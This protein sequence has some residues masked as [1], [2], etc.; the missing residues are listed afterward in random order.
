MKLKKKI[1]FLLIVAVLVIAVVFLRP[2]FYQSVTVPVLSEEEVA[3]ELG[4]VDT[5]FVP[6]FTEVSTDYEHNLNGGDIK[7]LGGALIDVDGDGIEEIFVGGGEGQEDALLQFNGE[8]FVNIASDYGFNSVGP[9]MGVLSV[10]AENDGDIDLFVARLSGLYLYENKGGKFIEQ[11]LNIEFS[12]RAMPF[13]IASTDIN[14]DGFVDLYISTFIRPEF[15]KSATFNDPNHLTA[16]VFLINDGQG[17]FE[18]ITESSGIDFQQNTFLSAFVDLN[19]DNLQDFVAATNTDKVKI[20]KN[21]GNGS[22]ESVGDFTDYGFWMGLA[23]A[24]IDNDG[25]QDLFFTNT[26]NT[27]PA[28]SARGDL[29]QN[30]ILDTEWALL[31]NDGNFNF[32]QVNTEVGVAGFEFAWGADFAD[33]NLDG[34]ED[35]LVVENYIKWPAHKLN[36]LPGRFLLQ[37]S[38][39]T[40]VPIINLAGV[41]NPFYGMTPLISDFNRDGYPDIVYLNLDGP[42]K[43]YLNDGGSNH[44]LVVEMPDTASALGAE[45]TVKTSDGKILSQQFISSTGLLSDQSSNLFFGLASSKKIE[46]VQIDWLSGD[47]SVFEEPEI[48]SYLEI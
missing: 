46:Y 34:L 8:E 25:D 35:L 42:V 18:D 11:N 36:K 7:F 29:S 39:G 3:T 12:S 40:F 15:L 48:D 22:F 16:N 9:T 32:S 30:Q 21:K 14:N 44:Y 41:E 10:D 33:M 43:A 4:D 6:T 24:D 37:G 31:R 26:G 23:I 13:D 19:N 5:N 28:S 27:V 1:I 2:F 47:Q 45:I 17:S 20:Y 38:D